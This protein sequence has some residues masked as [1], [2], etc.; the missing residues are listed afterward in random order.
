MKNEKKILKYWKNICAHWQQQTNIPNMLGV[1]LI[2]VWT[3]KCL[4]FLSLTLCEILGTHHFILKSN[5]HAISLDALN[6][7]KTTNLDWKFDINGI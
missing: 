4:F 6:G 3:V 5:W 2:L 1:N 7:M